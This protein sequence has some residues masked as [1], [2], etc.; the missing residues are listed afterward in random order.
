MQLC[1]MVTPYLMKDGK[2]GGYIDA[3]RRLSEAG[4][5]HIDLCPLWL[6]YNQNNTELAGD[7]WE[8]QTDRILSAAQQL[9]VDF[10]QIHLPFAKSVYQRKSAQDENCEGN[11]RFLEMLRRAI[12]ISAKAGVRWAVM[13]PLAL[14]SPM[15]MDNDADIAYN[16][17]V[18]DPFVELADKLGVGICFENL[19]DAPGAKRGAGS[20]DGG[21]RFGAVAGEVI[22]LADSF[23]SERVGV[24]WDF[25]HGNRMYHHG[26]SHESALRAVG[27]RLHAT[28]VDDNYGA[29]DLHMPPFQGKV[30]WETMMRTLKDIGYNDALTLEIRFTQRM[31]ESVKD[32]S[33]KMQRE[34]G[35]YLLSLSR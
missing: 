33:M 15:A 20:P 9:G 34:I 16:H 12:L 1:T 5:Q 31:P 26:D 30:N 24:C 3:I 25:G 19:C 4:F 2:M 27:K 10:P 23:H 32:T 13:H 7:D 11:P 21:R 18:Y 28:H 35:E 6:P 14:L 29:E 22:R 17:E 8:A